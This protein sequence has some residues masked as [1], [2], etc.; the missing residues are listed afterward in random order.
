MELNDTKSFA[1]QPWYRKIALIFW[2]PMMVPVALV[3][4]SFIAAIGLLAVILNYISECFLQLRMRWRGQYLRPAEVRR[5]IAKSGGTLIIENPSLGWN[6]TSAWWTPDDLPAISAFSTPSD[7]DYL[8]ALDDGKCPEW[9]AWCYRNY[10]CPKQGS[11][12]LLRVRSGAKLEGKLKNTF[13]EL[14]VVRT[15]TA[16]VHVTESTA[17]DTP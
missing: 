10:T 13:P 11:A 17:T 8:K 2:Y 15:W 9:D 12:Y 5:R 1:A 6:H 3:V 14:K 16:L 7:D 4:L